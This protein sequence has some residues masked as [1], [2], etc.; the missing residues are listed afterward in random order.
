MSKAWSEISR[1][2]CPLFIEP[3]GTAVGL[4]QGSRTKRKEA[5]GRRNRQ[6]NPTHL[7]SMF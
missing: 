7:N 5:T 4:C 2:E 1:V 3:R 6:Q